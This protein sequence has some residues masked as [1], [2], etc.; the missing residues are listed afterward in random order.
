MKYNRFEVQVLT[1]ILAEFS[2]YNTLPFVKLLVE[3]GAIPDDN[4]HGSA[5]C[6]AISYKQYDIVNF[7]IETGINIQHVKYILLAIKELD[8]RMIDL[9]IRHGFD[10]HLENDDALME[11]IAT[12]DRQ[13]VDLLIRHGCDIHTQ[14]GRALAIAAST[15]L[16][17]TRFFY[18]QGC[19][20]AIDTAFEYAI[21]YGT[22]EIAEYLLDKGVNVDEFPRLIHRYAL[23]GPRSSVSTI[24]INFLLDHG[25][26]VDK[27]NLTSYIQSDELSTRIVKLLIE[28]G[29][30]VNLYAVDAAI[31]NG[32]LEMIKLLLDNNP[33]LAKQVGT[34][35]T[36]G[37]E[38]SIKQLLAEYQ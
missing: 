31:Y 21:L 6:E 15:S 9:L 19:T 32:N 22:L 29:V 33:T 8:Y 2:K 16:E 1:T 20:R 25:A 30:P 13:M 3:L 11:A 23:T 37:N 18:E 27:I 12:G 5:I 4:D 38:T 28:R 7:F 10:I 17:L 36:Q 34:I 35:I 26:D 14:N 24:T